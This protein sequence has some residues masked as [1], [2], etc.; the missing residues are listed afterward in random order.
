MCSYYIKLYNYTNLHLKYV[1]ISFPAKVGGNG[2]LWAGGQSKIYLWPGDQWWPFPDLSRAQEG[3]RG[4]YCHTGHMSPS[5]ASPTLLPP[6][7]QNIWNIRII[8]HQA[9]LWVLWIVNVPNH[10]TTAAP[11]PAHTEKCPDSKHP[12]RYW[13]IEDINNDQYLN[14]LIP[15]WPVPRAAAAG[16]G[17]S[18]P[19]I[20]VKTGA[21]LSYCPLHS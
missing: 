2:E 5:V 8:L 12:S 17:F 9:P 4:D 1:K 15:A 14:I 18:R 21:I 6:P 13:P 10:M 19:A 7:G 3:R 11:L 16:P 20:A